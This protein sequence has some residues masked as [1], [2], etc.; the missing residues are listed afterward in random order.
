MNNKQMRAT[1]RQLSRLS[2]TGHVYEHTPMCVL[3]E[4]ADAHGIKYDQQD[5]NKPNFS[6]HLLASIHQTTVPCI[7][8]IK[9]MS[10]WQYVARFVNKYSQWPQSKLI[11]AYNFLLEFM[12]NDD[13]LN[14]I[15]P[16][17]IYGLQTPNNPKSVNA[18]ILYKTCIHHRLN[19]NART[20]IDQMAY[21]VKL[22][23][24]DS[25]SV[26]RRAKAFIERDAKRI[27]LINVL[28]LSPHEIQ[29]PDPVIINRSVDYEIL[30]KVETNYDHLVVLHQSLNDLRSLQQKIDPTTDSGCIALA[31]INYSIDISKSMCPMREYKILRIAGRNE[32]KPVD[33]WMQYWY[34]YNPLLFDLSV[35]FNP[36]FPASFYDANRLIAMVQNEGYT[37]QEISNEDPY[38]LLQLAYVAETF[39]QGEMPNMKSKQT[40]ISLD[41]I[42][43]VPYG[44]LLCFGQ[45]DSP[46]RPISIGELTDLFNANQNFSSPFN[47]NTVFTPIAINKLKLIAQSPS[48]PIPSRPLSSETIQ[49]RS[50]LLEAI[51]GVELLFRNNDEPTR[52]FAFS[53]RN[54]DPGTKQAIRTALNHLLNAGMYMRGWSGKGEYPVIKAPVPPER[55]P[56]VAINVTN[57]IAEY[58]SSC[59]S[60]GRLGTQLNSLPLVTYKDGQYQ[61]SNDSSNGLT[62]GERIDIVK[63]GDQCGNINSC[64]RL[65]SNWI[66]ASAHKYITSLGIPPPFDIFNLRHI[67]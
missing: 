5:Y 29:D 13:P 47:S 17:F 12:N 49:A 50:Q 61:T 3:I 2:I 62:I 23:R 16:D 45:L 14:K 11:Q 41:N 59:R 21:A 66:C 36:L 46:L 4:I 54:S 35:T 39:Y 32:Y 30:P 65:S 27:D 22:L 37:S 6:H 24:D 58:E 38:E 1:S 52:Q 53:Y 10:E 51:T 34:Q 8:E 9:E 31:A 42:N 48:G 60:L 28:M 57:S 63:Q 55:E 56:E 43:D 67:S 64:I 33:P 26:I 40:P 15:P 44:Q 18:C 20:T 25:E 19:I 7:G